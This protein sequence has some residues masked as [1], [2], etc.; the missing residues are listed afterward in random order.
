MIVQ[1]IWTKFN[2]IKHFELSA[3]IKKTR[4]GNKWRNTCNSSCARTVDNGQKFDIVRART[5]DVS[6]A[7]I[8]VRVH[9]T[10]RNS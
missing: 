3:E 2:D 10:G 5:H 9:G 4:T 8:A 6:A 1:L 7:Q